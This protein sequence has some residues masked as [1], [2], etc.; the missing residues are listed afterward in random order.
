MCQIQCP[1]HIGGNA[2]RSF[3]TKGMKFIIVKGVEIW[4]RKKYL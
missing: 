1:A 4:E 3:I 2:G